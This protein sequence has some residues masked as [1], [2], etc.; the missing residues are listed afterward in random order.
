MKRLL[1]LVLIALIPLILPACGEQE[2]AAGG[3]IPTPDFVHQPP[4]VQPIDPAKIVSDPETGLSY[5]SGETLVELAEGRSRADLEAELSR[6]GFQAK[7]VGEV[8]DFG[9]VQVRYEGMSDDD[10]RAAITRLPSSDAAAINLMHVTSREFNDPTLGDQDQENDWGLQKIKVK[11][12]WD[13]TTGRGVRVAVI[14]DGVNPTHPD[15]KGRVVSTYSYKSR[16]P[17]QA[18][19]HFKEA[20]KRQDGSTVLIDQQV[21]NHGTH[22]AGTIAAT[23]G[24]GIGTA[25]VAPDVEIL[26]YQAIYYHPPTAQAPLGHSGAS[27][28]DI[29][30]AISRAV[31]A[32]ANVINMSLGPRFDGVDARLN[33][34]TERALIERKV[35]AQLAQ[36]MPVYERVMR[37]VVERS[38]VVVVAAGNSNVPARF[39]P[40][41]NLEETITVG[42]TDSRDS[43]A[44]F[45]NYDDGRS[46]R[47]VDVSAPGV[48]VF[49]SVHGGYGYM[50]GTSMASP[51]VAGLAALLKSIAPSATHDEIRDVL[52]KTGTR[53]RTDK[54]VGPR[55]QAAAAVA[56]M[57]R[58]RTRIP[59][60][61]VAPRPRPGQPTLPPGCRWTGNP[62]PEIR[63]IIELGDRGDWLG[64]LIRVII[65]MFIQDA[66]R[67]GGRYDEFGRFILPPGIVTLG[68]PS[69]FRGGDRYAYMWEFMR[70]ITDGNGRSLQDTVA[71]QIGKLL[72]SLP[73]AQPAKPAKPAKPA[74]PKPAATTNFAPVIGKWQGRYWM[75]DDLDGEAVPFAAR[76][77]KQSNGNV[78]GTTD[79]PN[80][81]RNAKGDRLAGEIFDITIKGRQVQF[82]KRY[83]KETGL[84]HTIR[85]SG[86]LSSNA[87]TISGKWY[88]GSASGAFTMNKVF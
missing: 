41:A 74:E 19:D 88:I 34:P 59:P 64:Q 9:L 42:A 56:E 46:G 39:A 51:H 53:I 20:V 38:V 6:L 23:A 79:E 65:D 14:D 16:G 13:M 26:S 87:L 47:I 70:G 25:G 73:G 57:A 45:S 60:P 36:A 32:G 81:L 1:P 80:E 54:D 62:G 31:G 15:L 29:T 2:D 21:G 50:A 30:D 10:A 77:G 83:R 84:T 22:V 43:R 37:K 49:S 40:L 58:R 24:N 71:D 78:G 86:V 63:I 67:A 82:F 5:V 85:Y 11:Q 66:R 35:R 18:F 76:I 61:Q 68:P 4:S 75:T 52:V 48:R 17:K 7:V 8:P 72:D 3:A 55:I 27:L 69:N 12:A 33:D 28:T 44:S